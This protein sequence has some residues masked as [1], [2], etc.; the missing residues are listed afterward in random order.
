MSAQWG[1]ISVVLLWPRLDTEPGTAVSKESSEI[2]GQAQPLLLRFPENLHFF[3]EA[4]IA[5]RKNVPIAISALIS[6]WD[7]DSFEFWTGC[8]RG[9]HS[10]S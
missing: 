8:H 6:V 5:C 7:D 9:D 4:F 3:L 2:S 1:G 10:A